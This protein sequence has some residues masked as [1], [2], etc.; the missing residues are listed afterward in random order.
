MN[1]VKRPIIT[2]EVEP[3]PSGSLNT[4]LKKFIISPYH[5]LF[6]HIH[7]GLTD[8]EN[9]S[10]QGSHLS[11]ASLVDIHRGA[12]SLKSN[13]VVVGRTKLTRSESDDEPESL[14]V[15]EARTHLLNYPHVCWGRLS[16]D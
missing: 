4:D 9:L 10:F 8:S 5:I 12:E 14:F 15:L 6:L 1:A 3:L 13:L 2:L 7:I 16:K 11:S